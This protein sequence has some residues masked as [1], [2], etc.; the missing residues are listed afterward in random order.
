MGKSD[1]ALSL[2][3][4]FDGELVNADSRQVY[5]GMDTGTAKPT[6]EQRAAV[7]HH[8]L[9]VVAP[10]QDYS[11]ALYLE[12][13]THAI[14]DIQSRGKLPL[15]V[16]GAGLYVWGLL[17]GLRVPHVPPDPAFRREMAALAEEEGGIDELN[18]RL[19]QVDPES[20]RRIDPRNVR[21]VVRALEVH[22]ATGV[23]F[24]RLQRREP[25]PFRWLALGLTMDRQA[26]YLRIDERVER[27]FRAGLVDE[28]RGLLAKGYRSCLPSMSGLGYRQVC[29][30]LNNE[31]SLEE[32][33]RQTKLA[34]RHFGRR[35]YAWFRLADP[36]VHWLSQSPSVTQE[37]ADLV[38]Q[39]LGGN[40]R[41]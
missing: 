35:Q 27:M 14:H 18:H 10:D 5:A 7:P 8:L 40:S 37:A 26:L 28:V 41:T 15:L 3:Q 30:Y 21:R 13:A 22:R 38:R 24:S 36:R 2:A 1:L 9:D 23:P 11:L 32:A 29:A 17:E 6:P 16:G 20:A 25:P 4:R 34:T 33:V 12:Q 19:Q 31:M 39:F